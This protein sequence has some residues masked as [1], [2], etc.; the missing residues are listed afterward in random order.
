MRLG[1]FCETVFA[2]FSLIN[3]NWDLEGQR[4]LMDS[5]T[6]ARTLYGLQWKWITDKL[7]RDFFY[8]AI[9]V[10]NKVISTTSVHFSSFDSTVPQ[11]TA[12]GFFLSFL[13]NKFIK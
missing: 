3:I 8:C 7:E 12:A 1:H 4:K 11:F 5:T 10:L 13:C 2:L 9:T 6:A